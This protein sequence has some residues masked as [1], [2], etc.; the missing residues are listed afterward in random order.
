MRADDM[1]TDQGHTVDLRDAEQ[2]DTDARE[3]WERWHCRIRAI[4]PPGHCRALNQALAG[5]ELWRDGRPTETGRWAALALRSL[6][7]A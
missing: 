4:Y 7:P 5:A 1:Q 2:K 6:V 3:A